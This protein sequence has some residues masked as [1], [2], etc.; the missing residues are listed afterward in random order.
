MRCLASSILTAGV[1]QCPGA[2]LANRALFIA[3]ATMLW[4]YDLKPPT[5]EKGMPVPV[6]PVGCMDETV[7]S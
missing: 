2:E 3:V 6:A 1:R 7:T 5:D 4:S